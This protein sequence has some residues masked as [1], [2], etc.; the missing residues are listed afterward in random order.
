MSQGESSRQK[1]S[2][3]VTWAIHVS[4]LARRS[5]KGTLRQ[6]SVVVPAL[7][8]PLVIAA[9][10]SASLDR[11]TE[12]AGFPDVESYLQFIL[13]ATVIQ[14]V[15]FGGIL[16]GTDVALDVQDGFFDRLLVSPVSRT[17]II[18]GRL[19][20]GAVLGV[21]QALTFVAV[22]VGFGVPLR[23]GVSAVAVLATVALLLAVAIGGFAA[24]VGLRTGQQEAVQ[25]S[26]P[27]VFIT[28]FMS[29]AFFPTQ[30]MSGWF[31]TL[32]RNNPLSW[33]IDSVRSCIVEGVSASEVLRATVVA[34]A[35]AFSGV[36][37]SLKQ[38][39]W[40]IE[41]AR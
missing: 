9:V 41:A 1:P 36:V 22:F 40:R 25:N 7:L 38:L 34:G 14:G 35:L 19:V 6:P 13:P 30:L 3:L 23:S 8:F 11:A 4:A 20:G 17:S 32:A 12:L 26:F 28:L 31:G 33:L 10:N 37:L 16:A 15:L 39:A 27:L 18:V 29:S 21:L 5:L 2:E 24:A